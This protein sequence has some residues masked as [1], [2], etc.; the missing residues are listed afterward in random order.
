MSNSPFSIEG[1]GQVL[2]AGSREQKQ[3]GVRVFEIRGQ[4]RIYMTDP[5]FLAEE[6]QKHQYTWQHRG[7]KEERGIINF[8]FLR[9]SSNF[10]P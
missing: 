2:S 5:P 6:G 8:F 4:D 1:K 10:L 3:C 9:L 7:G